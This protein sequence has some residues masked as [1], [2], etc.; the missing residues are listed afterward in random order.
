MIDKL[1]QILTRPFPIIESN[2]EKLGIAFSFGFFI[3]LF[4]Y[5]FKPFGLDEVENNEILYFAG[6]GVITTLVILFNLFVIMNLFPSFYYPE[7]WNVW[8]S[9]IHSF[10][11]IIFIALM[12]WL[13]FSSFNKPSDL[14]H[15]FLYFIYITFVVG[16]IPSIFSTYYFEQRFRTRNEEI[17]SR[18][19]QQIAVKNSNSNSETKK[20]VVS[21]ANLE[22]S[23]KDFLCVKSMGNY[24]TIFFI[25]NET[26]KK[27]IVRTTMKKIEESISNNERIIRCHKSYFVNLNKVE[28]TSGNARALYLHITE[29]DFQIPVSRNYS[30]ELSMN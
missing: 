25:D 6:Y 19:N 23:Q 5:I 30:K 14:N 26:V 8:K 28:T 2:R 15:S 24:V 29:L 22:I 27:E 11:M 10:F 3:F 1:K 17:A 12:N 20:T 4:L 21:V 18:V 13:Y 7:K 16:A 9:T